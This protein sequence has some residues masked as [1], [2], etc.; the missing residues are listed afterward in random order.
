VSTLV[1]NENIGSVE[2]PHGIIV[3]VHVFACDTVGAWDDNLK[4]RIIAGWLRRKWDGR[5][6]GYPP[7]NGFDRTL[8][9]RARSARSGLLKP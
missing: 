9:A 1:I 7:E 5:P 3:N 8:D 2:Q 4:R 6:L